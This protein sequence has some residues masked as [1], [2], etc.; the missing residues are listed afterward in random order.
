MF[1]VYQ[2][3]TKKN[4][5]PFRGSCDY[6][7]GA[8]STSATG[9]PSS[10]WD[11]GHN[12]FSLPQGGIEALK[13]KDPLDILA[14]QYDIIAN[15]LELSSGAVRNTDP[16]I[17]YKAFDIA[18]YSKEHVDKK[19]GH[20]IHAFEFGAPPHCGFAPGIERLAML[21][22][23]EKNIRAVVPFPKNQR[24]EEPM[25]GSPSEADEKQLRE[26]HISVSV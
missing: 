23:G 20:M 26:L 24:A 1:L 3:M 5:T 16:E 13:T 17:M 11:F 19:F 12:P 25:M 6:S 8:S 14:W 2:E 18:G 4:K 9:G 15:G 22:L 7:F 21:L 10:G